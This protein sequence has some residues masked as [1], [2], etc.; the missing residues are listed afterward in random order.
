[1]ETILDGLMELSGVRATMVLDA[2]G[3]L[4]A[5]RARAVYDRA[6][7]ERFGS[8][9]IKAVDSIQLQQ[10]DWDTI[11]ANFTDGRI[12][13]RRVPGRADL[14][15][16]VLAVV[17]DATLNAPF[18]TVALRVAANKVRGVLEGVSSSVAAASSQLVSASALHPSSS[19]VAPA[20]DSRPVLANTGLSWSR[21]SSSVGTSSGVSGVPVADPASGAFLTRC[22]KE[23]ARHVGP[24]SKVYVQ[25]GVRRVSA[26]APFALARG[27]DLVADLAG[28][29]EDPEDRAAFQKAVLDAR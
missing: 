19:S 22:A 11:T 23:L 13:L 14:P 20:A 8:T 25:E 29:I 9:A 2:M 3:H 10:E 18:A 27:R 16:H 15:R 24:I 5:H 1:M 6:V 12:V 17:A 28:Q 21:T 4:V 26:E 7:C